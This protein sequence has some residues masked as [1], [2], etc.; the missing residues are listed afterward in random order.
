LPDVKSILYEL[1]YQRDRQASLHPEHAVPV[2]C[3]KIGIW[4]ESIRTNQRLAFTP[5]KV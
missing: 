4:R 3:K 2:V 5:H 1:P